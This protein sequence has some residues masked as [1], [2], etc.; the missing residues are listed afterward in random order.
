MLHTPFCT[1]ARYCVV[2]VRLRYCCDAVVLFGKVD[3]QV[4]PLSV[5]VSHL[6]TLP[7]WPES[8]IVPPLLPVQTVGP[9]L[10]VPPMVGASSIT[11][12]E[13]EFVLQGAGGV[14]VQVKV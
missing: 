1:T 2:V 14:M 10:V 9:P 4:T 13:L 7:S 3:C 11:V 6:T 8:V 12:T 5:D